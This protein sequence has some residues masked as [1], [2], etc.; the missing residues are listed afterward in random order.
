MATTVLCNLSE[1][2]L[3]DREKMMYFALYAVTW[4]FRAVCTHYCNSNFNLVNVDV[5]WPNV[6]PKKKS[7]PKL[8]IQNA[9]FTNDEQMPKFQ[10]AVC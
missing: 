10:T 7:K 9:E 6:N 4:P 5:L 2:V 1:I 3:V 8:C